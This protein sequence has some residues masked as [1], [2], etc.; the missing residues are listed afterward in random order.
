MNENTEMTTRGST[1]AQESRDTNYTLRPP[2]NIFEDADGI[3]LQADMP[4]V[5]KD[6]L[7]IQ[8]DKDAL[9][10]EG[11]LLFDMPQ[12][13]DALYADVR[14]T[15]YARSFALSSELDVDNV[16]ASLKD[17]VLTLR[18]PKRAEV[19]PRKVEIRVG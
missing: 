15:R 3:T 4:G 9:S 14:A 10:V 18:V 5:A 7:R 2:V 11:D 17:G 6:R 8:V 12:G 16:D 19:R 13:M 1:E